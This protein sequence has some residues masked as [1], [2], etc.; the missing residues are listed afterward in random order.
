MHRARHAPKGTPAE[1]SATAVRII[2]VSILRALENYSP[3]RLVIAYETG[4]WRKE[5]YEPYKKNRITRLQEKTPSDL[6]AD[7]LLAQAM[8]RILD[9]FRCFTN[10]SVVEAAGAEADDI[11]AVLVR[12]HPEAEHR[13]YSS[14]KDLWQLVAPNVSVYDIMGER[15]VRPGGVFDLHTLKKKEDF[16]STEMFLLEKIFRGD[17]SDNILPA[18]PRIRRTKIVEAFQDSTGIVLNNL[19]ET[20]FMTREKKP[21]TVR[22]QY[23]MNRRLIDLR[24]IP[25]GIVEAIL[26]AYALSGP[27]G[28]ISADMQLLRFTKIVREFEIDF[29]F[30]RIDNLLRILRSLK[31]PNE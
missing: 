30:A 26:S 23:L 16:P 27:S 10:A 7:R 18:F 3:T 22:E 8:E 9:F 25:E 31:K 12:N 29:P 1:I 20:T 17:P 5:I 4:S 15:I 21:V 24:N 6:E 19:L 28:K 14:D 2:L 11:I 13:I